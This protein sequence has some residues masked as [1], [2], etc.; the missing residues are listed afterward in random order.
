[1]KSMSIEFQGRSRLYCVWRCATG[2]V[3]V[4]N[5]PIHILEGENVC[6]HAITPAQVRDAFASPHNSEIASGLVNTGLRT[7]FSGIALVAFRPS[8]MFR[9]C[10]ATVWR[11][12]SPYKCWL[13]VT[14][15]TSLF[16]RVIMNSISFVADRK[17]VV[18]GKG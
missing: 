7:T 16:R 9:E 17:S 11:V 18:W 5:P 2:F 13:P 4:R 12:S 3:K 14:N 15:Q 1:M 6:I 8:T 10:S